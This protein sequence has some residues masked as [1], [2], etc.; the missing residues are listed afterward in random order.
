MNHRQ[1]SAQQVKSDF[2]KTIRRAWHF[3]LFASSSSNLILEHK[4]THTIT[5][6]WHSI[7]RQQIA[8]RILC[9]MRSTLFYGK[10]SCWIRHFCAAIVSY[11]IIYN[12][13][14]LCPFYSFHSIASDHSYQ[15]NILRHFTFFSFV[16]CSFCM[17]LWFSFVI[18]AMNILLSNYESVSMCVCVCV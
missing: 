17:I 12:F 10:V 1:K 2:V 8:A 16:P 9:Y 7:F 3:F 4:Y 15:R 14:S 5:K 6:N 18:F 13:G 11:N